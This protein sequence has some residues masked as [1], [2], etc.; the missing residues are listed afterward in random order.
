MLQYYVDSL[1]D[2]D[3][4]KVNIDRSSNSFKFGNS[5]M[6]RSNRLIVTI[7]VFTGCI[8]AKLTANV[9]DYEIPLLLSKDSMR[10][11]NAMIDFTN[12]KIIIFQKTVDI[13]YTDSNHYGILLYNL[14]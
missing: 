8:Q 6:I 3:K 13:I 2:S 11:T 12:D 5:K 4:D 7:P 10:R 14:I 1:S 9:T